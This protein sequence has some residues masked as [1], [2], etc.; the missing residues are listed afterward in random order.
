M[1]L[2]LTI[3]L[4]SADAQFTA[5]VI[6]PEVGSVKIIVDNSV[7]FFYFKGGIQSVH[8]FTGSE[9]QNAYQKVRAS[10]Y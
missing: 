8:S 3:K 10:C 4:R 1:F 9:S 7:Y 5:N 6:D 2:H